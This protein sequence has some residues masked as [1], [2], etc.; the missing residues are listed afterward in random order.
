[1]RRL[2]APLLLC[3]ALSACGG[4]NAA[5]NLAKAPDYAPAGQTKCSVR[6][7]QAEPLVVEWP[8]AERGRLEAAVRTGLVAVHYDGCEMQ[9]RPYCHVKSAA[10]TYA[11]V[12][13]K[14]DEVSIR[15][16]DDLY[17]QLPAGAA[18]LEAKL[19]TAGELHVEMIL[20]GRWESQRGAVDRAELEGDCEGATHVVNAATVGAFT[21]SAGAGAEVGGGA[22]AFG[23]GAGAS[24]TA[25]REMLTQDGDDAACAKASVR[26]AAPPDG[27][28]ALIRI[29][30][31]PIADHA[32]TARVEPPLEE[33]HREANIPA[34][35]PL[36][37][38]EPEPQ[39]EATTPPPV[40]TA[41][42]TP[43]PPA[44]SES[45]SVLGPVLGW[46]AVGA[47]AAGTVLGLLALDTATKFTSGSSS[48]STSPDAC[49][50]TYHYCDSTALAGRDQAHVEALFADGFFALGVA[51][52]VVRFFL[53]A[54]SAPS[55]QAAQVSAAPSRGG[56][57]MAVEG[58]F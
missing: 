16:A 41:S 6:K 31:V 7:S 24:S 44:G 3:A 46:T 18:R 30:V 49:N 34:P 22:T 25:R 23:A 29:E 1:V 33:P 28:G 5:S 27:C 38:P 42:S 8:P 13:R 50:A 48:G 55:S 43:A 56:A 21:F 58:R 36:S 52:A 12:T 14:R 10:Y 2:A 11:P 45:Q 35:A 9:L 57:S 40:A 20:V 4:G 17:T 32:R 37:P 19:K 26:D 47:L 39:P 15:D 53:P 51:A 54:P